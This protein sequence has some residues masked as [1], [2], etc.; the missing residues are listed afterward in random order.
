MS[1]QNLIDSLVFDNNCGDFIE[2]TQ[3]CKCLVPAYIGAFSGYDKI[4][5][6]ALPVDKYTAGDTNNFGFQTLDTPQ[7]SKNPSRISRRYSPIVRQE[8]SGHRSDDPT[9]LKIESNNKNQ[10]Y[11]GALERTTSLIT[12]FSDQSDLIFDQGDQLHD[13]LEDDPDVI[14]LLRAMNNEL[15]LKTSFSEDMAGP[16]DIDFFTDTLIFSETPKENLILD[17]SKNTNITNNTTNNNYL[18][19]VYSKLE[20]VIN[21]I[22]TE[23]QPQYV[24]DSYAGAESKVNTFEKLEKESEKIAMKRAENRIKDRVHNDLPSV[25]EVTNSIAREITKQPTHAVSNISQGNNPVSLTT[26]LDTPVTTK[27]IQAMHENQNNKAE[28]IKR[29][30]SKEIREESAN[31]I[32]KK[33]KQSEEDSVK[34]MRTALNRI[35]NS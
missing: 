16:D 6:K 29:E 35:L 22:A 5:S 7:L 34:R 19:N 33:F 21:S 27:Q 12:L 13:G 10:Y 18:N 9:F 24:N 25:I 30:I 3:I 28:I 4:R 14:R 23:N 2:S 8:F 1:L 17:S 26:G 31:T 15:E 32:Q 20:T 11:P